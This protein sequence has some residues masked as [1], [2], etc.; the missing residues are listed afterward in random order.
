MAQAACGTTGQPMGAPYT[1][2]P[3][4]LRIPRGVADAVPRLQV[5][6]KLER[7]LACRLTSV[8]ASAGFGK[9]TSV[10]AWAA[11][12]GEECALAWYSVSPQDAVGGVFWRY[13]C[14]ALGEA[15]ETLAQSTSELRFP[16]EADLLANA[17]DCL[18]VALGALPRQVVLV[19]DD[20]HAVQDAPDIASGMQYLVQN[21]PSNLHLVVTS[22]R[23]LALQLA[24]L[25]VAGQVVSVGEDDLRFTASEEAEFFMRAGGGP[26]APSGGARPYAPDE[27]AHIEAYTHGWPV[28]CRLVAMLGGAQAPGEQVREGMSDYLFEEVFLALPAE[29][30]DFL[31]KTS[32]V[33]SFCPSLAA[34]LTGLTPAQAA[35]M[36]EGLARGD[37]FIVR[38]EHEGAESWYRYHMLFADMLAL[39]AAALAPVELEGC[40]RAARDWYA[41]HGYLDQAVSLC[42]A[43][44]DWAGLRDLIVANWKSL[45]MADS[46]QTL[47][48]WASQ[49][50]QA[51]VLESPFLCAV[52]AMPYA[53]AGQAEFAN[54]LIMHA[55]GRLKPGED[56][57]FA[58]C[59]AQKAFLASFKARFS[60]MRQFCE[61]ALKYLPSDEFYLRGM[62]FQVL[63]SSYASTDPLRSRAL[64]HEALQ[65]QA[66]FG[67]RNLTCS[68]LGNLALCCANLGYLDEAATHADAALALYGE[69]ERACKPMLSHARLA[70]AIVACQEGRFDEAGRDLDAYRHLAGL[71][72]GTVEMAAQTG[73][74]RAKLLLREGDA[75]GAQ[76]EFAR[77]LG[78][79]VVGAALAFPSAALVRQCA[80]AVR[81]QVQACLAARDEHRGA[82][83]VLGAVASYCLGEVDVLACEEFCSFADE[84]DE[85][86]RPLAV[87][88]QVTAAMLC[89][90]A[91]LTMRA[92]ACLARAIELAGQTQ[93]GCVAPLVAIAENREALRPAAQRL[94][95]ASRDTNVVACLSRVY[96]PAGASTGTFAGGRQ[97]SQSDEAR[98][99]ER[100]LDVMRLVAAGMSV[101]QAAEHMVVS[102]ETV[103]KHLANI[104]GKLGVH[105]KMQAVAL[106]HERGML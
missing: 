100:E 20:F 87:H 28:G 23:P 14:A 74:L 35:A 68:A 33:E 25:R 13:V 37:L 55:V 73:A 64:F 82:L 85:G 27:L 95:A 48:R 39:R 101:A 77:A 7:G 34:Q 40:R 51:R 84:V 106:L 26:E 72:E 80:A 22:R 46:H 65:V 10:A 103:K 1:L 50:S 79:D 11:S 17:I 83:R 60:D 104:Y 57:L 61:K 9:T 105:S 75:A 89:E 70:R 66:S 12:L 102:R 15:D 71:Q 5:S 3:S 94:L 97:D 19:L 54:S 76:A 93:A 49:M 81:G 96:E 2:L 67:N 24:R 38:I 90:R 99:T 41:R 58:L 91:A 30:R 8:V 21:M 45:Y 62:M 29:Q 44:A 88:A 4:K 42:V 78:A 18:I 56:F 53:L 92:D 69:A 47:V 43:L 16:D 31:I 52:L 6:A 36:A 86:Q 32:V 59:M 98:L 63:A